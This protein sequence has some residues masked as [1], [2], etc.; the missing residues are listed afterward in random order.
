MYA[1]PGGL[2]QFVKCISCEFRKTLRK[3]GLKANILGHRIS[4]IGLFFYSVRGTTKRV[5]IYLYDVMERF[6]DK[7]MVIEV[8]QILQWHYR[9]LRML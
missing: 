9:K 6:F 7:S 4:K 8:Q 2:S 3:G 5:G 1:D